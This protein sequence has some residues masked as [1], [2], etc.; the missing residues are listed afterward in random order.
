MQSER[1]I[2]LS[3]FN[4]RLEK[5]INEN[6]QRVDSGEHPFKVNTFSKCV[7]GSLSYE[8]IHIQ[9]DKLKKASKAHG[10]TL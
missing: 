8:K 7:C 6:V 3:G 4:E 5:L 10:T 1:H 9:R 2:R